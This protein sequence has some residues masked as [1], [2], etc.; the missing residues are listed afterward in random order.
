MNSNQARQISIEKVLQKLN[1]LPSKTIGNDY[2]YLSPFRTEVTPS[3]KVNLKLNRWFDHGEQIG[4]NIIDFLVHKFGFSISEALEYLKPF[5]CDFSFQKQILDYPNPEKRQN[6]FINKTIPIQHIALVQYLESRQIKNYKE[7]KQLR[8]IH[9]TINDKDYFGIGFQNN[10]EGWEI[11]SKYAK[12]C[13]GK[14]DI[15]V[16]TNESKTLRIYE[17][18][19]DYLSFVQVREILRMEESDYLILNSVAL[20]LKNVPVLMNYTSIELYLDNDD[21]G[22]NYTE[23][24]RKQFEQAVDCRKLY[25][26]YEDVNDWL[27]AM[28]LK[29]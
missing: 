4:G 12:I 24:I 20:L 2:W 10:S 7:V 15:T 8:E 5:E 16:I 18:F 3:F 27:K 6:N 22:N 11:R 21:A 28:V 14:K 26:E 19:F 9:Y 23:L 25:R 29:E 13:L 1:Y 17:G